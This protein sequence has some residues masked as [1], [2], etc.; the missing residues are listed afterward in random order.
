MLGSRQLCFAA[1]VL[2]SVGA[3][4]LQGQD[5]IP[6]RKP[7]VFGMTANTMS[8]DGA[9]AGT[10][11]VGGR[12]WGM[13]FDGGLMVKR[14]LYLGIDLGPQMLADRASF[15][16]NTTGG[17]LESTASLVYFSALAGPRTRPYNLVPGMSAIAVGLYGGVSTTV[18]KRSID[19][20]VDCRTDEMDI[21]GG[22]FVQPTLLF[23][24]GRVR[25]RVS[26]RVFVGG[27]GIRSVMSAGMELGAQ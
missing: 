7:F 15:T 6:A 12:S 3:E 9:T 18:A 26:D 27:K 22:P 4:T 25:F 24:A 13:Q 11:L 23:G 14:H 10:Q 21:P 20:C 2:A 8:I 5:T 1:L 17:E 19:N 16:Q